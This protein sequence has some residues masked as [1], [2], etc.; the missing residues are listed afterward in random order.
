MLLGI[1]QCTG[2]NPR[3][4]NYLAP[5]IGHA[6]GEKLCVSNFVCKCVCAARS[7]I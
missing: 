2:Q 7:C 5:N 4:K 1:Q 6:V 3:R